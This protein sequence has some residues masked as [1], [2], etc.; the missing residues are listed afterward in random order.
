MNRP[1]G[2]YPYFD[3]PFALMAHRGGYLDE[4]DAPRE[5]SLYAF[6][7]AMEAGYRYLE[8]DVHATSDGHLVAFHDQVLDRVTDAS[9]TLAAMSFRQVRYYMLL[10]TTRL[11]LSLL[12]FLK[13]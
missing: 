7:R 11:S 8:T 13:L 5:N 6:G 10:M 2:S 3:E 1:A 9:G 4:D 12:L